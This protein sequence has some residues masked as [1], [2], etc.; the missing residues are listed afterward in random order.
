MWFKNRDIAIIKKKV[1]S[2]LHGY[3]LL[4][5]GTKYTGKILSETLRFRPKKKFENIL[6]VYLPANFKENVIYNKKNIITNILY[7][8]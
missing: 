6:I 8:I 1:I 3:V 2:N 7:F 5:V 4:D